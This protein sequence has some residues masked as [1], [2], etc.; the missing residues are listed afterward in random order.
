MPELS[1]VR[2]KERGQLLLQG[3]V[4]SNMVKQK[5]KR[6]NALRRRVH[7]T[8]RLDKP[9]VAAVGLKPPPKSEN[10]LR[11]LS[12]LEAVPLSNES[13]SPVNAIKSELLLAAK[14]YIEE[15]EGKRSKGFDISKHSSYN[16]QQGIGKHAGIRHVDEQILALLDMGGETIVLPID[17]TTENRLKR[18]KIGSDVRLTKQ[19]AIQTKGIKL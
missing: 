14:K 8:G 5:A 1:L 12:E 6:S 4:P 16:G 17:K 15:R 13:A 3:D 19:G 11:S 2:D 10:R 18:L 7:R 9:N